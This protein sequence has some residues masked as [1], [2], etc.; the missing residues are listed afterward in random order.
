MD[1]AAIA[2]DLVV[3]GA[4]VYADQVC[5]NNSAGFILYY[6]FENLITGYESAD[7]GGYPIDQTECSYIGD[8]LAG[9]KSGD[10]ILLNVTAQGGAKFAAESALIYNPGTATIYF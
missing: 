2:S 5:V 8:V 1:F 3:G 6:S 4:A 7:Q 9:N 10:V